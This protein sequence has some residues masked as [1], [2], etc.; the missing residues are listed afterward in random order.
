MPSEAAWSSSGPLTEKLEKLCR[1]EKPW[2]YL[3]G[4]G[5]RMV[6][7][8]CEA[9]RIIGFGPRKERLE[10]DLVD[11]CGVHTQVFRKYVLLRIFIGITIRKILKKR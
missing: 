1:Q 7:K 5:R 10:G 4:R 6:N 8:S 9:A 11:A 2:R 3:R